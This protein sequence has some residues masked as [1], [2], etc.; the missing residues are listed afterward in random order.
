MKANVTSPY[1]HV[2]KAHSAAEGSQHKD[3][4]HR[5][6]IH[7]YSPSWDYLPIRAC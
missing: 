1:K 6:R 4:L 2:V 7:V 5:W 3:W